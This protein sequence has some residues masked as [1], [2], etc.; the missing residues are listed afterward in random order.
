MDES[1]ASDAV[2]LLS[3]LRRAGCHTFLDRED[4]EFYCSPPARPVDWPD[5]DVE[6]AMD[7]LLDEL[8]DLLLAEK[9]T[10]H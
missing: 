4:G 7:A 2:R 1:R 5:G 6:E 9:L 10:V 8:R 3:A